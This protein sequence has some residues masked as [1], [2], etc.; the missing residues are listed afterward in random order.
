MT[1]DS[2]E[3]S[4]NALRTGYID[5]ELQDTPCCDNQQWELRYPKGTVHCPD[6]GKEAHGHNQDTS[7]SIR[8]GETHSLADRLDATEDVMDSAECL[9]VLLRLERGEDV[10][11]IKEPLKTA[12]FVED[13]EITDRGRLFLQNIREFTNTSQDEG[14]TAGN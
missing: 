13:G 8:A 6:C 7:F 9:D 10:E 3:N 11:E 14:G 1:D 4:K 5:V 2:C 12:E